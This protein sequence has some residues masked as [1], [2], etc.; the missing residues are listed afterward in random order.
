MNFPMALENPGRG[1]M[2]GILGL[3]AVVLLPSVWLAGDALSHGAAAALREVGHR[4]FLAAVGRS[5]TQGGWILFWSLAFGWPYGVW[6][7]LFHPRVARVIQVLLVVPLFMPT[8]LWA[9]GLANLRPIFPYR[10]QGWT[11]GLAGS[12][13]ALGAF[14]VPLVVLA[15]MRA[16][17]AV[18]GSQ[19]DSAR[20]HGGGRQ[21]AWLAARFSFPAALGA[22]MLGTM[23]AL[24][25]PG[26]A[27]IM[28]YH[29]ASSEILIAFAGRNDLGLAVVKSLGLALFLL[30]VIGVTAW[31]C[32]R[33]MESQLVASE[34][35]EAPPVPAAR[36][37]W[38]SGWGLLLP[39][40]IMLAVPL[41]GLLKPLAP[42]G[43][44]QPLAHAWQ[45]L[46]ESAGISAWYALTAAAVGTA[47]GLALAL[48]SFRAAAGRR[49]VL[50]F[51]F[52]FLALSPAMHA[53]G[54]VLLAAHAS[55]AGDVI[56][57]SGWLVG[58]GL[59]L[60]F[61]PLGAIFC[62]SAASKL[63]R[64]LNHAAAVHGLSAATYGRRILLPL[65]RPTLITAM[66]VIAL[67]AL[68][69]VSGTMLLAP[70]GETTYPG[71]I[72]AVMDNASQRQVAALCLVYFAAAGLAV[73]LLLWFGPRR[74]SR[75][76]PPC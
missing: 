2:A 54:L 76:H 5:F 37:R 16:V 74:D 75:A 36:G 48:L 30:P 38:L 55:A 64:S 24:A 35:R 33:L 8:F 49:A 40:V 39:P 6:C 67:F 23:L 1:R 68:A 22:G 34:T 66:L 31:L 57:R 10:L 59:G 61:V 9:I 19:A 72:F 52:A 14:T 28:G 15:T 70:P 20:L 42:P 65:L 3:I 50:W 43:A 25:D 11:D 45:V 41:A 63:P 73:L 29:G 27:Q 46:G 4:P 17:G 18:G 60:R 69:D 51:S 32:A 62:L 12:V 58:V 7:A 44:G 56:F 21:L 53:L 26:P 47:A 13:L 71:R